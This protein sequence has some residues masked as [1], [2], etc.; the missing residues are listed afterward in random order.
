MTVSITAATEN[1]RLLGT[2][3]ILLHQSTSSYTVFLKSQVK[4]KL[5]I[6]KKNK[7][8]KAEAIN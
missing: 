3:A 8:F 1:V 7:T 6:A 2:S 5:D 4:V